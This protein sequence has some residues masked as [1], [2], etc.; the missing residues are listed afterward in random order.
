MTIP[1]VKMNGVG[2]DFVIIDCRKNN[3]HFSTS[4]IAQISSHDNIGCD[5]FILLKN[6][7]KADCFMDIY[8]S[9][10]SNSGACGNATRCVA[11]ILFE[12][13]AK[14]DLLIE[15]IS[16]ILPCKK[17]GNL[18]AVEMGFPKFL[19]AEIPLNNDNLDAQNLE[20]FGYKFH[21]LN[22]GNPHAV[23][24]LDKELSDEEFFTL[25]AKI[26][27]HELFPQKTNVEFA[28]IISDD[29]IKVR[30]FERGAGETLACGS[31]ACAVGVL[32]MKHGFIKSNETTTQFKG[33]D[34]KIRW[35]ENQ[36]VTMIGS[37]EKEF[38][39]I[40]NENLLS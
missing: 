13:T 25:G 8:N 33:G 34:I 36:K 28:Q 12:E 3:Y 14:E 37:F 10:G 39:G 9:D 31:G 20:I 26:E 2:N 38:E 17:E 6:S 29:L 4:Q 22:I 5:Q 7:N 32:A 15:T 27:S 1:F 16:G 11:S 35:Q 19:A 18:I 40:I 24:F 23:T 21:C 30:V